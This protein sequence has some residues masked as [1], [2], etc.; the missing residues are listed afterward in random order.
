MIGAWLVLPFAGLVMGVLG[1]CLYLGTRRCAACELVSTRD[2]I[3]EIQKGRRAPLQ[4]CRFQRAWARVNMWRPVGG[5][6]PSRLTRRSHRRE[7]EIGADLNEDERESLAR[8][9]RRVI[10]WSGTAPFAVQTL[11]RQ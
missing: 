2:D 4:V 11:T 7:V 3:V 8:E 1:V 9:L 10:S 6:L 5:G